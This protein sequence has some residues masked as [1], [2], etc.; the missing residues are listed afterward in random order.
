MVPIYT[1]YWGKLDEYAVMKQAWRM[2][3]T[4][5]DQYAVNRENT[6]PSTVSI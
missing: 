4:A 1:Q 2:R 3:S 6:D 5:T